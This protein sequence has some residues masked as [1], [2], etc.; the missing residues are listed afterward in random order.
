[1]SSASPLNK[2]TPGRLRPTPQVIETAHAERKELQ[3]SVYL[4]SVEL[5]NEQPLQEE[6]FSLEA[7]IYCWRLTMTAVVSS[8]N[9]SVCIDRR[10]RTT[11]STTSSTSRMRRATATTRKRRCSSSTRRWA[12]KKCQW[13]S[14]SSSAFIVLVSLLVQFQPS[15]GFR[16]PSATTSSSSSS[17]HRALPFLPR[18]M[19]RSS[20]R[21]SASVLTESIVTS[22]TSSS[23]S[24]TPSTTPTAV[25]SSTDATAKAIE[26][27]YTEFV[28]PPD[29]N[30]GKVGAPVLLLHGL[31]GSK[32]NFASLAKSLGVQLD[33][34]RRIL[35]VDLRNHG[36]YNDEL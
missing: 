15:H 22:A 10:P 5:N 24:P 7:L 21:R 26:L 14:L 13:L 17:S 34:P 31:L 16:S 36:T 18:T 19:H 6:F 23:S 2:T 9:R 4:T 28:V 20:S 35:G 29:D 11:S 30:P 27:P 12:R 8:E 1:M 3:N 33:T 25:P 32:R